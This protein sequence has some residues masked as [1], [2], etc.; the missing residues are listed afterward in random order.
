MRLWTII[1]CSTTIQIILKQKCKLKLKE[2]GIWLLPGSIFE[3]SEGNIY[4]TA[5]VIN[6]QGRSSNALPKMFPFYP[7]E[8]GVTQNYITACLTYQMLQDLECLFVMMC[9]F[10][11]PLEHW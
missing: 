1:T 6:P 5:S 9:G 10:Q 4:N 7:Y 11:K 3:K 2:Y 8:T